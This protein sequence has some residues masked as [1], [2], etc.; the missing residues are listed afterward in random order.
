MPPKEDIWPKLPPSSRK[1][2]D[3]AP[4]TVDSHAM[5]TSGPVSMF[6]ID[7]CFHQT[8]TAV[9]VEFDTVRA[10]TVSL[11]QNMFQKWRW[12]QRITRRWSQVIEHH[13]C[14]RSQADQLYHTTLVTPHARLV[15]LLSFHSFIMRLITCARTCANAFAGYESINLW[16]INPFIV[17]HEGDLK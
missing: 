3:V 16:L 12:A 15:C 8:A 4:W 11:L 17:N 6:V 7:C 9:V 13:S 14:C 5:T 1:V 10:V 2:F